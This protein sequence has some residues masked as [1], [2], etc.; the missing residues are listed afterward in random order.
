[1]NGRSPKKGGPSSRVDEPW[2]TFLG[3]EGELP[4]AD[5]GVSPPVCACASRTPWGL[6][7]E[8]QHSSRTVASRGLS[9]HRHRL[10]LF[11]R[12]SAQVFA[13][14][15][16]VLCTRMVEVRHLR[17]GNPQG[18]HPVIFAGL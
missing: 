16:C 8:Y 15:A 6:P 2:G 9:Q 4:V 3:P 11:R 10:C 12:P 18:Q 13:G 1:M 14:L 17:R 7:G 5:P